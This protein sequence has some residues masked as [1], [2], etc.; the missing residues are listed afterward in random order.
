MLAL[1]DLFDPNGGTV[2]AA[3]SLRI[4]RIECLHMEAPHHPEG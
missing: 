2:A 3:Q 4:V 1:L